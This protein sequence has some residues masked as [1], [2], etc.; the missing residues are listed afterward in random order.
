LS[1]FTTIASFISSYPLEIEHL[2]EQILLV[3][4]QEGL[5]GKEL[6]AIDGCKLPSNASKEW[7]GTFKE[8][9]EKR[10]KIKRQIRYWM[11]E[12]QKND[13][14]KNSSD[15]Q[16]RIEKTIKTLNSS[17]EKIDHFLKNQSPRI[18]TGKRPTEVKSNITD[19]ESAK[20]THSP[21]ANG[22]VSPKGESHG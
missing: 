21:G 13:Q 12:H 20:M 8:L 17:F 16:K 2:F 10:D 6:F 1:T 14:D 11:S 5:L 18:G 4:D 22:H 19:N 3:C 7:S 15:R 9:A